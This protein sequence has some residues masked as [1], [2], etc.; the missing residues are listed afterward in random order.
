MTQGS[1]PV[2]EQ[3]AAP[4]SAGAAKHAPSPVLTVEEARELDRWA[5]EVLGLPGLV[6]MENAGAA[7]ARVA[8]QLRGSRPGAVWILTGGGNNGGD[9]W[10]AARHLAL[11][12]VPVRVLAA[13]APA[14]LCGDALVM[15]RA[16]LGLRIPC[17]VP[18]D[19]GAWSAWG[20]A[21]V[22]HAAVVV[23]ALLGTGA[24]GAPRGA[25]RSAIDAFEAMRGRPREP[26]PSVLALDVPSGL[27]ADTGIVADVVL[28]ADHT[29]TFAALKRGLLVSDADRYVGVLEV[30]SIGVP[31]R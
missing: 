24:R 4:V 15:A 6:L 8:L 2:R 20:D 23:D 31:V 7:A 3:P 11:A 19:P 18:E 9:G 16:A 21:A 30:A 14:A 1:G 10:V 29:L 28:T 12:G 5:T 26:R 25:V 27:D 13:V 22:V 17:A